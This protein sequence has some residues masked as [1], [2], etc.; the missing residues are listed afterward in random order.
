M[1][2]A[3]YGLALTKEGY[4]NRHWIFLALALAWSGCAKKGVETKNAFP[5]TAKTATSFAKERKF[6]L[7]FAGKMSDLD[8]FG[9]DQI[10]AIG[11]NGDGSHLYMAFSNA[12][13]LRV[14]NPLDNTI[15]PPMYYSRGGQLT[16]GKITRI[17]KGPG[18]KALAIDYE[19]FL[20]ELAG[21]KMI[22][23]W[24]GD[25]LGLDTTGRYSPF[26][27][28]RT[29]GF[30]GE[31]WVV[32]I[33]D[34][35]KIGVH[36]QFGSDDDPKDGPNASASAITTAACSGS[37]LF[38]A[39]RVAKTEEVK[40]QPGAHI[41]FG[42]SK[43]TGKLSDVMTSD[44][45]KQIM[46]ESDLAITT[47]KNLTHITSLAVV[48]DYLIIAKESNTTGGIGLLKLSTMEKIPF[49]T[50]M[51]YA[52]NIVVGHNQ[53]A[54]I[55]TERGL[56]LFFDGKLINMAEDIA[57]NNSYMRLKPESIATNHVAFTN[58][59]K[60]D[61]DFNFMNNNNIGAAHVGDHWYIGVYDKGI[62]KIKMVEK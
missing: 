42:L 8:A 25:K 48:G 34:G 28:S 17:V 60:K 38:L 59:S 4:M 30:C 32:F 44:N 43:F 19:N 35:D 1:I 15:P 9:G 6:E 31:Q 11:S 20:V 23:R 33:N 18:N 61:A 46:S 10:Q 5:P 49:D 13:G 57:D 14:Y 39:H 27:I 12:P 2:L 24:G 16:D 50:T 47:E 22:H 37:D 3:L 56:V 54:L 51:G 41:S 29:A 52:K 62:F 55:F 21:D 36:N 53:T 7:T 58:L 26:I 40:G 45:Y